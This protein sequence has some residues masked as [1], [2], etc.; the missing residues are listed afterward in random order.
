MSVKRTSELPRIIPPLPAGDTKDM[1]TWR[2]Y[3]REHDAGVIERER[4]RV[5]RIARENCHIATRQDMNLN[6]LVI[7]LVDF[8]RLV[9]A[10]FPE[11]RGE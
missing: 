5:L 2:D 9:N 4:E 11:R 1:K 6:I 3:W 10:E 7:P 8:A